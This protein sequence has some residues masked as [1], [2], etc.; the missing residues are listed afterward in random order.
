MKRSIISGF[1]L[2]LLL[3]NMAAARTIQGNYKPIE[4]GSIAELRLTKP[5]NQ[6]GVTVKILGYYALGDGVA[7][8]VFWDSTSTETDN[9]FSIFKVSPITT[10]RYKSVDINSLNVMHA[11]A[12]ADGSQDDLPFILSAIAAI[13]D[14][15]RLYFPATAQYYKITDEIPIAKALTIY[16][17]DE[18]S[19]IRQVTGSKHGFVVTSSGVTIKNIKLV[20]VQFSSNLP[21]SA[22]VLNGAD[23]SNYLTGIEIHDTI[24]YS[25][26]D[27]GITG[28]F[29]DDF[30]I[31]NNTITDC[32]YSGM[33][34]SSFQN[35]VISGNIVD[36]IIG[37][38]NAYGITLTKLGAGGLAT[39]PRSH[40][41]IV[42]KNIISN[43]T[44][45]NGLDTHG[46]ENITFSDNI[47]TGCNQPIQIGPATDDLGAATWAP[48]KIKLIGN[49]IDSGST[50]GT[51][52]WGFNIVG[53]YDSGAVVEYAKDCSVIG[54]T[55]KD[56][57]LVGAS[58]LSAYFQYT[59]GLIVNDNNWVNPTSQGVTFYSDNIGF[60]FKNNSITDVWNEGSATADA[61]TIFSINNQGIISENTFI[62]SDKSASFKN[63]WGIFIYDE[64]GNEIQVGKNYLLNWTNNAGGYILD[65]GSRT[66]RGDWKTTV[67]TPASVGTHELKTQTIPGG[68][69]G[70]GNRIHI[71]I[72]GANAGVTGTKAVNFVF[73]SNSTTVIPANNDQSVWTVDVLIYIDDYN[74]ANVF[75]KAY[76]GGSIVYDSRQVYTDDLTADIIM[77]VEGVITSAADSISNYALSVKYD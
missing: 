69:L 34:F 27:D 39:N 53:A 71:N 15:G 52:T 76:R 17:D 9:G 6:D 72:A 18:Q 37:A 77:K 25:W 51:K 46:G 56:H 74:H 22:I 73:G 1:I 54:N 67:S 38:P 32:Y 21:E 2:V 29:G 23:S 47:V 8:V 28:I 62:G 60:T 65:P 42:S 33:L 16:G 26:G 57:G 44:A 24:I 14:G 41:I 49:T 19:E 68:T 10:G 4:V 3:S 11:G 31:I 5:Q 75:I 61:I 36:N 48:Q 63:R 7:Q 70:D 20:G 45:W 13:P 58:N 66:M 30:R 64:V 50:T 55:V 12:K 40:D 35:G 43:V 59:E